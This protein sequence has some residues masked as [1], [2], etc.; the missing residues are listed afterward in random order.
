LRVLVSSILQD[1][2]SKAKSKAP[3]FCCICVDSI[4]TLAT[5]KAW[6]YLL[7]ELLSSCFLF[8][9]ASCVI[10]PF[11]TSVQQQTPKKE[12]RWNSAIW[13]RIPEAQLGF[14]FLFA[15]GLA[16][17]RQM[18]SLCCFG[19]FGGTW[20]S[21]HVSHLG[22]TSASS[23]LPLLSRFSS[24]TPLFFLCTNCAH[25]SPAAPSIRNH[26][27]SLRNSHI[28]RALMI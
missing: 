23:K 20:C 2:Q 16:S 9:L 17:G 5:A 26:T 19:Y 27:V 7:Q 18:A 21:R 4:Q 3:V 24:P 13:L 1:W 6:T 12:R 25:K 8:C 15:V 11:S 14:L 28:R 10:L 22:G